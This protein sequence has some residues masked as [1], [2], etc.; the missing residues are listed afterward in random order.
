MEFDRVI[1]ER[2]SVRK[3]QEKTVEDNII[4]EILEIGRIAPSAGCENSVIVYDLKE[5]DILKLKN[6]TKYTFNAKNGFLICYDETISYKR[7][8]GLDF[9]IQDASIVTTYMML[10]IT[11]LGLGSCWVGSFDIDKVSQIFDLPRN[12]IPVSFLPF[13]Y[14]HENSKPTRWHFDRKELDKFRIKTN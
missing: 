1:K 8:D 14:I 13:G 7:E 3:F 12:I 6:G 10:K 2:Y 9:G 11:E 4:N 5:A